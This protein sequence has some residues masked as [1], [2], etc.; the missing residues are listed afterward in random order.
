MS[1]ASATA[2]QAA[3]YTCLQADPTL[4]GLVGDAVYDALPEGP[5]PPLYVLLGQGDV[6]DASDITGR[7]SLHQFAV[8]VVTSA[9]GFAKSKTAAA[10]IE[11][12]L[13]T[14]LPALAEGHLVSVNFVKAQAVRGDK[15]QTRQIALTFAARIDDDA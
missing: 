5:L 9:P 13:T 6:R 1:Y 8:T 4:T 10:A 2:L 15:G 11:A 3:V 12:A 14:S 7:G